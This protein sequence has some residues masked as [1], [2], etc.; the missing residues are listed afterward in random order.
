VERAQ[1]VADTVKRFLQSQYST[2]MRDKTYCAAPLNLVEETRHDVVVSKSPLVYS[3]RLVKI[4]PRAGQCA[5]EEAVRVSRL[6][7]TTDSI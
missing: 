3:H 1:G 4:K 5:A 2:N 7:L 6:F